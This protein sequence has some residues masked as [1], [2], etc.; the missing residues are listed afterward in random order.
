MVWERLSELGLAEYFVLPQIGWE[1]KSEGVRRV[2]ERLR[3]SLD[4]IA[5]IDDQPSERAEVAFHLPE[6]RCY[7]ADDVLTLVDQTEFSPATVTADTRRRREMYQAGF[8]REEERDA[9]TGPDEAFLRSL[10]LVLEITRVTGE[11]LARVE[12]LT[13]RTSQMNA[14][15]VHYMDDELRALCDDPAHEVLTAAMTDRFGPH[16]SIGVVLLERH[17]R[18]W[19]LKLLATSCRVVSLGAGS[20]ILAWLINEAAV[21]G[22]HLLADFRSTARNRMMEVAYRFAGFTAESCSCRDALAP[23]ARKDVQRLHLAPSE[24]DL[25]DTVRLLAPELARGDRVSARVT[26]SAF[27]RE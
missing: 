11:D 5:F 10:D 21:A 1:A 18:V 12:E 14:T 27:G 16:G 24:R 3:F 15:G 23:A 7:P 20:T 25:P 17:R 19:H 22:V 6:V 4:M 13:L 8:R 9:F 26:P 2:A